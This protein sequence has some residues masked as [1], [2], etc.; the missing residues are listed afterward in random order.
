[1]ASAIHPSNNWGLRDKFLYKSETL[2]VKETST[3]VSP[4]AIYSQWNIIIDTII[5]NKNY[6]HCNNCNDDNFC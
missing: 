5:T 2:N 4:T 1:M 6:H 3:P